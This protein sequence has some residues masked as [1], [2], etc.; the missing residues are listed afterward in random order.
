MK[1]YYKAFFIKKNRD[2]RNDR[3][4]KKNKFFKGN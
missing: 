3:V 4:Y 1:N 2:E